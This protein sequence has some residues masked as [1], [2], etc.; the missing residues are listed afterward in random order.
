[1]I[2]FRLTAAPGFDVVVVVVVAGGGTTE[3]PPL[4]PLPAPLFPL[5]LPP[6]VMRPPLL[7]LFPVPLF[8][9]S[10]ELPLLPDELT[11]VEVEEG[12]PTPAL[13]NPLFTVLF[14][15]VFVVDI[16]PAL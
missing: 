9:L 2:P 15:H 1:M 3:V 14:A 10:L 6:L 12:V 8:V 4:F 7:P 5:P 13:S 16:P 11:V